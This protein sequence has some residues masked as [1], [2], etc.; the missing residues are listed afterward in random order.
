VSVGPMRARIAAVGAPY[1]QDAVL[2]GIDRDDLG[3][4]VFPHLESCRTLAP[5]LAAD[6]PP[7]ALLASPPVRA[8]FQR[9]VDQLMA[10]STGS[11]TRVMRLKLLAEPPLIDAGEIT[12]KG[13]INQR[14]VLTRRAAI[15][16]DLY[17]TDDPLVIR[18]S[19][20]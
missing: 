17:E 3:A 16:R 11:A 14:A 20:P 1:V 15:V 8:F 6:A 9:L 7:Q 18:P 4:L 13:S 5:D 19:A 12:D 2:T 10:Q